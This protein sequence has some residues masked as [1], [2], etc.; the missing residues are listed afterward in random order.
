MLG[1][2]GMWQRFLRLGLLISGLTAGVAGLI[3]AA[4]H[5]GAGEPVAIPASV[6]VQPASVELRHHR[7]PQSLQV[8]ATSADGFSLDLR[9]GAKFAS[10]D[11]KV[12]VVGANGW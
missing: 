7:Q 1:G 2:F 5:A 9:G 4:R 11:A 10:A 6:T 8:L 3:A 12:A